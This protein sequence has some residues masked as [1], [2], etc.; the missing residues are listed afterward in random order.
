MKENQ[1]KKKCTLWDLNPRVLRTVGLESTPLD[2][3]GKRAPTKPQRS[4][5]QTSKLVCLLLCHFGLSLLLTIALHLF[6]FLHIQTTKIANFRRFV[7]NK[8]PVQQHA[9]AQI[10]EIDGNLIH[11]PAANLRV[12]TPTSTS[13]S[14]L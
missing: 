11:R 13:W 10:T 8:H 14:M 7:R 12:C 2:H 5:K 1:R 3:S 4:H 9:N 6:E